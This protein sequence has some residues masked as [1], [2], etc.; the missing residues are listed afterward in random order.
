MKLREEDI[1]LEIF[2]FLLK[3]HWND[4]RTMESIVS[5]AQDMSKQVMGLTSKM[6]KSDIS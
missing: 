1:F 4:E 6:S 3:K 5:G 2:M